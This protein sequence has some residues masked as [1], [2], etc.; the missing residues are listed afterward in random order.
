[1][2]KLGLTGTP[3]QAKPDDLASLA[4]ALDAQPK[5]LQDK[6]FYTPKDD[7]PGSLNRPNIDQFH[8]QL[9]DRVD[10]GVLDLPERK[11]VTL[12]YDP[13]VGS[14][15]HIGAGLPVDAAA[16]ERHNALIKE[17]RKVAIEGHNALLESA[18]R[19][20]SEKATQELDEAKWGEGQRKIFEA[21]IRMGQYEFSS[22][23]GANGGAKGFQLDPSLLEQA[24]A[25]PSQAMLLIERVILNRQQ[26]CHPRIAIFCE[27]VTELEIMKR[28][29]E[30][31]GSKVG[32]LFFFESKLSP[33]ARKRMI[34]KF[35]S[36][37]KGVFFFSGAGSVGI[38]LCP[39]CEVLLSVGPLPWN[40]TTID[41][42]FGRVYRIGQQKPVE[43]V[44]FVARRSVTSV[45]LRLHEDKRNRLG[46]AAT[47][48]D[49]RYFKANEESKWRFTE[50]ILEECTEL[51]DYGN[52]TMSKL[53][54]TEMKQVQAD[55]KSWGDE[56]IRWNVAKEQ[57]HAN[58]VAPPPMPLKPTTPAW[59]KAECAPL[60]RP[61]TMPLPPPF[62]C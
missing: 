30:M 7:K 1:V 15:R 40:P 33:S 37:N 53:R 48:Q 28:Y 46:R 25:A 21:T 5:E 17:E 12:V 16:V 31:Q 36:C 58:G 10:L 8:E 49:Y 43:I 50:R 29:L 55:V 23:L 54:K 4:Q 38:T 47:D 27:H 45:K 14:N 42:A 32:D 20:V 44:Q 61:E 2:Y 51:D 24:A 62:P 57:A 60:L 22:I 3:V 19:T 39:G 6:A 41:Q 59:F 9:V 35:L 11:I 18:R 34:D 13:W 52:Y 56:T 26:A